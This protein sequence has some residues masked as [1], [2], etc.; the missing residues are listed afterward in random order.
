[1]CCHGSGGWSCIAND[2]TCCVGT[3]CIKQTTYCCPETVSPSCSNGKCPPRC[4]PR[5]TVCCAKGGRDGCCSPL[6]LQFAQA[7]AAPAPAPP[8][9]AAAT[10][11]IAGHAPAPTGSTPALQAEQTVFA[12]FLEAG[13]FAEPL[14]VLTING[15]TGSV[16]SKTVG[17]EYDTHGESTR[18]FEFNRATGMFVTFECDYS[19]VP[20]PE[21]DLPM[22]MYSISP[23]DGAVTKAAVHTPEGA[24][25]W[26]YPT[27]YK[28]DPGRRAMLLAVG[29]TPQG[30][31][32]P[33]AGQAAKFSFYTVSGDGQATLL[34]ATPGPASPTGL[35]ADPLA[36]W[37]HAM[38]GDTALRFGFQNVSAGTNFGLGATSTS[39]ASSSFSPRTSPPTHGQYLSLDTQTGADG[40]SRLYS[41]APRAGLSTSMDLV[42]WSV[43]SSTKPR[44][45]APLGDAH[46][47]S[48]F[49]DVAATMREDVWVALTV[50]NPGVIISGGWALSVVNVSAPSPKAF[51]LPLKPR[52]GGGTSSVSG[53]GLPDTAAAI[54]R[55]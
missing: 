10:A 32:Y 25:S 46:Q 44:V 34:T 1:V 55:L 41:M 51:L 36:G 23:A 6:E 54:T 27:G 12:M 4:C 19:Q 15:A 48:L 5:W 42:E 18:L 53:I 50:Q 40:R 11:A 35:P 13:V 30:N 33:P 2:E 24:S 21:G 38:A 9:K 17:K 29:P 8:Q 20:G 26:L 22:H 52:V 37:V 47:P 3:A 39:N 49:G 43:A 7:L 31:S 45:L 28:Y 14:K 16:V